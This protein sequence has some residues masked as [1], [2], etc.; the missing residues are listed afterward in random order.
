LRIAEGL[1]EKLQEIYTLGS[2]FGVEAAVKSTTK[3]S[4]TTLLEDK[5]TVLACLHLSHLAYFV[6]RLSSHVTFSAFQYG[7]FIV[8]RINKPPYW[9]N[10]TTLIL[11]GHSKT[12]S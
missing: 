9:V 1:A 10:M 4:P 5:I 2:I 8:S 11:I 6:L 7:L 3:E 12:N